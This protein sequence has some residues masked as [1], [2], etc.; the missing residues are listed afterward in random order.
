MGSLGSHKATAVRR[1]IGAD[2]A[3]LI[4]LPK[5]APDLNPMEPMFA[6]LKPW[7]RHA[8]ERTR[9]A[10]CRATALILGHH[11]PSRVRQ[12]VVNSCYGRS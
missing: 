12:D 4:F 9:D 6:R 11:I 5:Y 3:T 8:A 2:S 1:A 7:L 10:L